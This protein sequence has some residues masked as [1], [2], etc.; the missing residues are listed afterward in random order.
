MMNPLAGPSGPSKFSTRT[1]LP[2][3][4]EYSDRKQ[5]EEIIGGADTATTRGIADPKLGRPENTPIEA[6]PLF[7]PSQRPDESITSGVDIGDGPGSR[8]MGMQPMVQEKLSDVLAKMIPYDETG[9]VE[10]LYQ[11]ALARG[12]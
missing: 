7:A 8:D 4:K 10:I 12:M 9:E 6:I 11:R 2:P 1:D 5:M 3:S